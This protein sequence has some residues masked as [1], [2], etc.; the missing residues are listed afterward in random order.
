MKRKLFWRFEQ[1]FGFYS[2]LSLKHIFLILLVNNILY[3]SS[4]VSFVGSNYYLLFV[5][6][7]HIKIITCI[8]RKAILDKV[9][10][11]PH[12]FKNF[13]TNYY[14][15]EVLVEV[16]LIYRTVIINFYFYTFFV[17]LLNT[18]WEYA[19]HLISEK[20]FTLAVILK[21]DVCNVK[22]F[23]CVCLE[24]CRPIPCLYEMYV[25]W[26]LPLVENHYF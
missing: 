17:F 7:I 10:L 16:S 20:W 24:E 1:V 26:S 18:S 6:V 5:A 2:S 21:G 12:G 11:F 22:N 19:H 3:S 13:F 8:L 14:A 9:G 15:T 4:H 23:W 25:L